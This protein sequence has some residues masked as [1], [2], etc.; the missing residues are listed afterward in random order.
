MGS[1]IL[2]IVKLKVYVLRSSSKSQIIIHR[3]LKHRVGTPTLLSPKSRSLW[4]VTAQSMQI[5]GGKF[6]LDIRNKPLLN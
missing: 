5:K 3:V 6:E 4:N 2:K 1:T